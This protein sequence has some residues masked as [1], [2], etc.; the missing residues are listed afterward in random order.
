MQ[1]VTIVGNIGGEVAEKNVGQSTV[2]EFSV[3]CNKK[4]KDR[5]DK[6]TWYRC[7]YWGKP[8]QAVRQYLQKGTTV[9]VV[10]DLDV[11]QY[12]SNGKHGVSCDVR[13]D[14]LQLCGGKRDGGGPGPAPSNGDD[15]GDIPF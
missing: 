11:R 6:A 9:A 8:A 14:S 2:V 10:G 13:V 1:K 5:D 4:Q 7:S 3:A 15:S 12:E